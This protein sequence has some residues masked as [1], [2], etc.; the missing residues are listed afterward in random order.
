MDASQQVQGSGDVRVTRAQGFLAYHQCTI[1]EPLSFAVLALDSIHVRQVGESLAYERVTRT[2]RFFP[3]RQRALVKPL[4][5]TVLA[6]PPIHDGQFVERNG[7]IWMI[8]TEAR[9]HHPLK[10]LCLG[11]GGGVVSARVMI[12]KALVDHLYIGRLGQVTW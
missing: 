10:L 5:L 3:D 1:E 6:L 4:R 11:L 12:L 2:E 7:V 9:L 8:G